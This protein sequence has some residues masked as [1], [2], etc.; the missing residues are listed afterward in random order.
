[1]QTTAAVRK[2]LNVAFQQNTL[3]AQAAEKGFGMLRTLSYATALWV[4]ASFASGATPIDHGAISLIENVVTTNAE[5]HGIPAQAVVILR[6]GESVYRGFTGTSSADG[7]QVDEASVFPAFS[8]SKLFAATLLL[9]L[10]EEGALDLDAP[11]SRYAS[12]LPPAWRKITLVQFLNHVSGVPEYFDLEK[13]FPPSLRAVFLDLADVP[14]VDTPGTRTR[15]TNTNFLVIMA[16]L[17]SVTGKSYG[18]LVHDRIVTPLDLR[19]TWLGLDNVPRGRL[20]DSYRS[21]NDSIVPDT[22]IDWPSYSTAHGELYSTA[23]DLATFLTAVLEGRFVSRDALIRLWKP[24]AFPNGNAGFFAS[25]WE[26]GKSGDWHEVGHDGG[27]KLRVRILFQGDLD[28]H[29][30]FVYLTN[31]SRDKVWSRTLVDSVQSLVLLQ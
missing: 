26:Y 18:D 21:E 15:Y 24:H 19:S 4:S 17:E 12:T 22:P 6:N 23:D 11:A 2:A 1:M 28:E 29:F 25:G 9:Q 16:I 27:A 30:V 5:V 10:V 14:F 13:P 7:I 31:G 3:P 8:V 20:V